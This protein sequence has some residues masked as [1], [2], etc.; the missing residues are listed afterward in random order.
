MSTLRERPITKDHSYPFQKFNIELLQRVV[1]ESK[2]SK[3]YCTSS[4]DLSALWQN[5]AHFTLSP[6]IPAVYKLDTEL[7]FSVVTHLDFEGS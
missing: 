1:F 5:S 7:T 3:E 6:Y 4:C 2:L